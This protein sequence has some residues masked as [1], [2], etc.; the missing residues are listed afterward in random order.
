MDFIS[1]YLF[2]YLKILFVFC[3]NFSTWDMA[4]VWS[5]L[6]G[7]CLIYT[8]VNT[9]NNKQNSSSIQKFSSDSLIKKKK[10][11]IHSK[12]KYNNQDPKSKCT[13]KSSNL[14]IKKKKKKKNLHKRTKKLNGCPLF[15]FF[16]V[17]FLWHS[18]LHANLEAKNNK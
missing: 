15:Y 9:N 6:F 2:L 10:K 3:V 13:Q 16:I 1:V 14:R 17:N 5:F 18:I 7:L 4:W 12:I 8:L 11:S